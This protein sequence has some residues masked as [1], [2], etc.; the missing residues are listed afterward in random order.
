VVTVTAL[1]EY[2]GITVPGVRFA[3]TE[4][5]DLIFLAKDGAAAV[6][7]IKDDLTGN[8]MVVTAMSVRSPSL[9]DVFLHLVGNKED[10]S[11]FNLSS[12]RNKTGRR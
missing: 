12:F 11:P 3:G 1:G 10:T 8:G 5:D 2:P 9:D 4:G 7:L 6:P